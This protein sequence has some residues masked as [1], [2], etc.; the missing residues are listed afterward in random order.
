[1]RWLLVF[2]IGRITKLFK[3]CLIFGYD[4]YLIIFKVGDF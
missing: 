3:I 1:M 2:K 4:M